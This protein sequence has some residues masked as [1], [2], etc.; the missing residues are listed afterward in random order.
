MLH[1]LNSGDISNGL[2][3]FIILLPT[4]TSSSSALL[5]TNTSVL[6][7]Y[8]SSMDFSKLT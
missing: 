6:R 7:E 3:Q 2:I 8:F 1:F 4:R 5:A